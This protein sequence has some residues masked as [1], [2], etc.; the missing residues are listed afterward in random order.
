V[1][2]SANGKLKDHVMCMTELQTDLQ[3]IGNN[4]NIEITRI[5]RSCDLYDI[6]DKLVFMTDKGV[7]TVV[8]LHQFTR[9][10][11]SVYIGQT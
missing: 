6:I 3:K 9:L 8:P 1:H 11:Y 2:Y 4:I 5:W 10:S 7:N